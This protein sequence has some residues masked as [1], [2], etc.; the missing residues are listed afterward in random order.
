MWFGRR[1]DNH[2]LKYGT[3]MLDGAWITH[4]TS[5]SITTVP[6][7]AYVAICLC[8]LYAGMDNARETALNRYPRAPIY[9]RSVFMGKVWVEMLRS[10]AHRVFSADFAAGVLRDSVVHRYAQSCKL[11]RTPLGQCQLKQKVT[12]EQSHS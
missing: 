12:T 4:F 11:Q 2:G 3:Q 5:F 1:G 10:V 6:F 9:G 7:P 8:G